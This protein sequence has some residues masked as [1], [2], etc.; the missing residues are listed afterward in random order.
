MLRSHAAALALLVTAALAGCDADRVAFS[1][2]TGASCCGGTCEL[3]APDLEP[4]PGGALYVA[5]VAAPA[6]YR[7]SPAGGCER[8]A[9]TGEAGESADGV[10]ATA[11]AI[12]PPLLLG[13]D[14]EDG[15][16]VFRELSTGATRKID[17]RG[18][19]VTRPLP[20]R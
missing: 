2:C 4:I 7:V 18:L 3:H 16:L 8:L 12:G 20:A 11:A 10:P 19:L 5:D 13:L 17:G 15:G 14:P 9:G 6:I 1:S